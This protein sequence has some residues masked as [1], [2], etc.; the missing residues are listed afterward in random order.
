MTNFFDEVLRDDPDSIGRKPKKPWW[1]AAKTAR[2]GFMMASLYA[3]LG[4]AALVAAVAGRAHT[5][6]F[7]VVW[8]TFAG[9]YLVNAVAL[10]RRERSGAKADPG[11]RPGFP[12][13][14]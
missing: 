8:L 13:S 7:A 5:W 4:L 9:V 6:V 14:S 1:Q 2:Q 10:R 3:V 11:N 12:P